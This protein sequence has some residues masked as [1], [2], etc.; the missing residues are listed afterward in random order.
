MS[1]SAI[2][3]MICKWTDNPPNEIMLVDMIVW[4]KGERFSRESSFNP[5]VISRIPLVMVLG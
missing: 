4:Y 3:E 1:V 2:W 5:M